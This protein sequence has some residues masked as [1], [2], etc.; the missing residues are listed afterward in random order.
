MAE[1]AELRRLE[2]ADAPRAVGDVLDSVEPMDIDSVGDGSP[3]YAAVSITAHATRDI[4]SPRHDRRARHTARSRSPT[5]LSD[6]EC[7]FVGMRRRV[8]HVWPN[9][10]AMLADARL[11]RCRVPGD[12]ACFYWALLAGDSEIDAA[13]LERG[14]AAG[15]IFSRGPGMHAQLLAGSMRG[16]RRRA[17]AW[18]L[19]PRRRT[20]LENDPYLCLTWGRFVVE[21]LLGHC[22]LE[23]KEAILRVLG[24]DDQEAT[25]LALRTIDIVHAAARVA[26]D[27]EAVATACD[28]PLPCA[29]RGFADGLA[30]GRWECTG[31]AA[32]PSRERVVDRERRVVTAWVSEHTEDLRWAGNSQAQAVAATA[33]VDI[34]WIQPA[35]AASGRVKLFTSDG[36]QRH[37]SWHGECGVTLPGGGACGARRCWGRCQRD[38]QLRV[39]VFNGT[40]HFEA[41]RPLRDDA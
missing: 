23:V 17:V 12:G 37:V 16:L 7:A 13:C 9:L 22:P 27:A 35:D 18:Q 6:D 3:G 33:G 15:G 34:A 19:S 24:T 2:R 5:R 11:R 36:T 29:A 31:D 1:E 14:A 32:A 40:N 4:A 8:A 10:N 21:S 20:A 26:A 38:S 28:A 41:T 39:V 30:R 25:L